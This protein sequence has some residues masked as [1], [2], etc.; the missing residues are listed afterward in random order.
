MLL[1]ES[2]PD[3]LRALRLVAPLLEAHPVRKLPLLYMCCS[4]VYA[5]PLHFISAKTIG[6]SF[7]IEELGHMT[8]ECVSVLK[9]CSVTRVGVDDEL[10]VLFTCIYLLLNFN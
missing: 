6:P 7:A 10:Y 1:P 3:P 4:F 5:F 9:Q 8:G 2:G